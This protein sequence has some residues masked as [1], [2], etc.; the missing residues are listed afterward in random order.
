M[1]EEAVNFNTQELYDYGYALSMLHAYPHLRLFKVD[2]THL[3]MGDPCSIIRISRDIINLDFW[4][5]LVVESSEEHVK[6]RFLN[7]GEGHWPFLYDDNYDSSLS[8]PSTDH[9]FEKL[10]TCTQDFTPAQL[11][12][13]CVEA[14][15]H[16]HELSYP[17]GLQ[18]ELMPDY[19]I[20]YK[21]LIAALMLP[22]MVSAE[23]IT[24][25]YPSDNTGAYAFEAPGMTYLLMGMISNEHDH[26]RSQGNPT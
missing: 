4:A 13:M 18:F 26:Y 19:K 2:K 24:V 6:P 5:D 15:Q 25:H 8:F 10:T 22:P 9:V 16:S 1:H 21:L 11:V 17:F 23:K 20:N 7:M 14:A 12:Q 3:T